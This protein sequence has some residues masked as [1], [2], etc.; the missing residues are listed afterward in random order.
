[1]ELGQFYFS[2]IFTC[3]ATP[4]KPLELLLSKY[5]GVL[6]PKECLSPLRLQGGPWPI[7]LHA[8]AQTME[9]HQK[10]VAERRQGIHFLN[11]QTI[12]N[13]PQCP[14]LS[15]PIKLESATEIQRDLFTLLLHKPLIK[16]SNSRE[17]AK[18]GEGIPIQAFTLFTKGI[19]TWCKAIEGHSC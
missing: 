9:K 5:I 18:R 13:K 19:K 14:K 17:E 12:I 10:M 16:E 3:I 2:L 1:M 4:Q 6:G 11:G 15:F 8:W 7:T